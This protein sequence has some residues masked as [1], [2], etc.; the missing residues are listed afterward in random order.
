MAD[1][2]MTLSGINWRETVQF[3]HLFRSFRV[4]IHP[5]KLILG[6]LLILSLY[7]GGRLLDEIWPNRHLVVPGEV[8]QF[9]GLQDQPRASARLAEYR[10][11]RQ[12]DAVDDYTDLLVAYK[13]FENREDARSAALKGE[14][15]GELKDKIR[16]Q[17]RNDVE[18]HDKRREE[19]L[20]AADAKDGQ[21]E[22]DLEKA[23][24]EAYARD[25]QESYNSARSRLT[26][27]ST[28]RNRGI[29]ITFFDYEVSQVDALV[30]NVLDWNWGVDDGILGNIY[31]FFVTGPSWLLVAHPVYFFIFLIF[32]LIVWAIF[33]GAIARIAA[34]HVAREEKISIRAALK[35]SFAKLLSFVFAP[36]I[37]ILII[38]GIGLFVFL[39]GLIGSIPGIGPILLGALFFLA[40]AAGFVMTLVL[41]GLIG[42]FNLMYPT[43]AVEGSDSFDAISRSFSYLYARPWKMAFYTA[44]ALVYG[45]LTFLFVR[46]FIWLTLGLTHRFVD[47]G[48]MKTA[49]NGADAWRE[50]WPFGQA[51][52][53]TS[54]W[55]LPYDVNFLALGPGEAAG[56]W[57]VAIWVYLLIGLLGAF[58]ISFYFSAN[59]IIYYLMRREVDATEMDD[60]Y[61]EQLDEEFTETPA[62]PTSAATSA[63]AA[64]T[65]ESVPTTTGAAPSASTGVVTP[66]PSDPPPAS[67]ADPAA[68]SAPPAPDA[69]PSNPNPNP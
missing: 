7:L 56:A 38:L 25:V 53:A 1:D 27:A 54:F 41:L 37:P 10:E 11:A 66:A 24:E 19:A 16:E 3:T 20:K 2:R 31:H 29:F 35:F 67:P 52:D 45:A 12:R 15:Y 58:A 57:L 14:K 28:I 46:F 30:R 40:L 44:V 33:G 4:A 9:H 59:T 18:A 47:A 36:L 8:G 26:Q 62:A 43:I 22:D 69:P 6:L 34:V 63:P 55:S 39:G 42:G 60:V 64:A 48:M 51:A 50:M 13:V 49:Y 32:F 17:L 68:P 65:G 23:A 5:S 21:E 61:V